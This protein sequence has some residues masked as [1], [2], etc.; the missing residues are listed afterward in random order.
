MVFIFTV[1]CFISLLINIYMNN[2]NNCI[3]IE[4]FGHIDIIDV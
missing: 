2:I 4:S 3:E 1:Y